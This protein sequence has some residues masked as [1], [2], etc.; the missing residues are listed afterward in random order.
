MQSLRRRL[1]PLRQIRVLRLIIWCRRLILHKREECVRQDW[2]LY[3]MHLISKVPWHMEIALNSL[4]TWYLLIIFV[5]L[6]KKQKIL[7]NLNY[8]GSSQVSKLTCA[9]SH[10]EPIS[11]KR[12]SLMICDV[13]PLHNRFFIVYDAGEY[14]IFQLEGWNHMIKVQLIRFK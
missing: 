2:Y 11:K 10:W 6:Q 9:I 3:V 1:V 8:Y 12:D 13:L 14:I 4:F 7:Q 5:T